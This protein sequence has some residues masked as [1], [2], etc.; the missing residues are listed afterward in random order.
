MEDHA[1]TKRITPRARLKNVLL[2]CVII[3]LAL[4]MIL[5]AYACW[6]IGSGVQ[7][8]CKEATQEY[9]G[10]KIE[11]LIAYVNSERHSL[12]DRNRAVWALGQLGEK[13]ALPTL[14]KFYT[15]LPCDHNRYLCQRELK[16]AIELCR[17]GIN[18]TAWTWR[19]FVR[20]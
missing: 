16:K 9:R 2:V 11:A 8:M 15:G 5:Y 6:S 19:R 3:C 18:A 17:G 13:Q 1:D 4:I 10:D 20:Q 12:R 7:S 14:Q